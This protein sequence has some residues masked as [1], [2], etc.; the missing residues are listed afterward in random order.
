[1]VGCRK[2]LPNINDLII[3]ILQTWN[4]CS[5]HYEI[6]ET[7]FLGIMGIE[8]E[9]TKIGEKSMPGTLSREYVVVQQS[10]FVQKGILDSA[11]AWTG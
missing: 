6:S 9:Q 8:Q 10:Y 2:N 11:K 1:M 3:A 5:N 4:F 7:S